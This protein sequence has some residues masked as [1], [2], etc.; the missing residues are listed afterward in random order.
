MTK[1]GAFGRTCAIFALVLV[2]CMLLVSCSVTPKLE[3]E[4]Q[5]QDFLAMSFDELEK[6]ATVGKYK[7]MQIS[8]GGKT[9]EEAV[10][11]AVLKGISV[12]EYP[13]EH[14][15]YYMSQLKG[16]YSYYAEQAGV[17]YKE[18]LEQLGQSETTILHDSKNMT[19]KDM[20]YAIIVKLENIS[21]SEDEKTA[22]FDRYVDKYVENYGYSKDYVTAN[23]KEIIYDS[24][25]YDKTTE[26]LILSNT[27]VE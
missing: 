18:I 7:D 20:A 4:G 24:M 1:L 5:K 8:L 10:W 27:F 15:Y 12:H 16:Q 23:M 11:D 25:L 19:K 22:Y 13:S 2:V 17:S 3:V 26:F 14:V 9:K 6:Y 21:L